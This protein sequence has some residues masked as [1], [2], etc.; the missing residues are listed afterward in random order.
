MAG[1]EGEVPVG[2]VVVHE[3]RIIGRGR[4]ACERLQDATAHAEMLAQPLP[5][6]LWNAGDWR[7]APCTSPQPLPHVHGRGAQFPL[8]RNL[9]WR[10]RT[11]GWGLR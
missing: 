3:G 4:N 11:E 7:A 2:A 6:T 8:G 5:A 10:Y 1:D 9:L